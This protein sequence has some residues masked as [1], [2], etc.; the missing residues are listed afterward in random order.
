MA[1]IIQ[2]SLCIIKN[3]IEYQQNELFDAIA[4]ED[5]K[6]ISSLRNE[7]AYKDFEIKSLKEKYGVK[8]EVK[9]KSNI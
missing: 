1:D 6:V 7:I 3:T 5:N 9:A 8:E 4:V 2:S